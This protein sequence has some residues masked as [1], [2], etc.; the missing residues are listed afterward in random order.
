MVLFV[1]E[2]S[3]VRSPDESRDFSGRGAD[4]MDWTSPG[5]GG[6]GTVVET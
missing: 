6:E 5:I 3:G 2:C 4:A 1:D